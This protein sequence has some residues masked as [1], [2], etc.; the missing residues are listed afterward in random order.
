MMKR[1][2]ATVDA[3]HVG[4]LRQRLHSIY[5]QGK[6][7]YSART[8]QG[9]DMDHYAG[10]CPQFDLN[11]NGVIDE[12][13]EYRLARHLG[14]EVRLNGYLFAYFGGDWITSGVN[15]QPEHNPGQGAIVK[16][17]HGAGYDSTSGTIRLFDT[18]GPNKP[19][20]VEYHHDMPAA[21]GDGNI[22]IHLFRERGEK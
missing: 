15:F 3:A 6:V 2:F 13:D 21:P 4:Q 14:R 9:L 20:W 19:V 8:Q 10:Y 12:E 18:P 16:Y 5:T 22:L 1:D 17:A 7:G 11:G